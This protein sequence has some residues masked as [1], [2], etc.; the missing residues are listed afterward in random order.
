[1]AADG[2]VRSFETDDG[3]VFFNLAADQLVGLRNPDDFRNTG[4]FFEIALIDLSLVSGDA[5]RCA[6]RT[7]HRMRRQVHSLDR[8]KDFV[9]LFLR[10]VGIHHNEHGRTVEG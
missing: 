7:G 1:M 5:D 2:G 6:R 3:V 8:Q 4:H 9:D 10:G